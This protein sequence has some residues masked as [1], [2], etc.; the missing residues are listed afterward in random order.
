MSRDEIEQE[1]LQAQELLRSACRRLHGAKDYAKDDH[2]YE[3]VRAAWSSALLAGGGI[4][5]AIGY[6]REMMEDE[7]DE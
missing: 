4:E 1:L 2:T 3:L 7:G 5:K 6:N